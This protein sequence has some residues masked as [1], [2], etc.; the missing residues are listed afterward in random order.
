M[1]TVISG[2]L[3]NVEREIL[4]PLITLIALAAFVLDPGHSLT[5]IEKAS[6]AAYTAG[7]GRTMGLNVDQVIAERVADLPTT[8]AGIQQSLS[9]ASR[10]QATTV[11]GI[12]ETSDITGNSLVEATAL[13]DGAKLADVTKR[14]T[15][16]QAND[17]SN[18][19]GALQT[20]Q[21]LTGVRSV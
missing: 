19:G 13:G 6:R 10:L 21:G 11:E 7:Y 1:D 15:E 12:T 14:L 18:Q 4:T 5:Q 20:E 16:R 2:F 9:E 3:A 8:T 17:R